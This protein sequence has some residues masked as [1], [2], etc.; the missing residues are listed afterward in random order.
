M[1]LMRRDS[2]DMFENVDR[3]MNRMLE[4]MRA[5]MNESLALLP[6]EAP[7]IQRDDANLLA[8]DMTSDDK[9]II[10]RTALPG[11]KEDEIDVNVRG[12]TLTISAESKKERETEQANW[13]IRELRYGKFARSIVLPEEVFFDKA[14]AV[15]ENGIL[16][17]KLPKQ[18][19]NPIQ[20]IA[21]KAKNLLKSGQK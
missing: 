15:L 12:N 11:F 13:H 9:N 20:R 16:T 6:Y 4:R 18:K 8:V 5:M 21:V 3:T 1:T 14:E 17:V 2:Y 19:P 7:L 10:V